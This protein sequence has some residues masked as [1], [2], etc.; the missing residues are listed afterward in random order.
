[1]VPEFT[2][3]SKTLV[4]ISKLWLEFY[5][6]IF[7]DLQKVLTSVTVRVAQAFLSTQNLLQCPYSREPL[8]RTFGSFLSSFLA[9]GSF[10]L[11]SIPMQPHCYGCFPC[12]WANMPR[13]TL[14]S[15]GHTKVANSSR[16]TRT[17]VCSVTAPENPPGLCYLHGSFIL[18]VEPR[19]LKEDVGFDEE[20][21]PCI[22]IT[23]DFFHN[24]TLCWGK[25][26]KKFTEENTSL[27]AELWTDSFTSH[28]WWS[29]N[30][31]LWGKSLINLPTWPLNWLSC[32]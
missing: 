29:S 19:N 5:V 16:D 23:L 30:I 12:H 25:N 4:A 7:L 21:L 11:W 6:S 27:W 14:G 31:I 28:Q 2:A 3:V 1:M 17:R 13:C 15:I 24:G 10:S 9:K 32:P 18:S 8:G 22:E 20:R 26:K